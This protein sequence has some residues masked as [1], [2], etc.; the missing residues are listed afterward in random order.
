MPTALVTG[1]STGLG[2]EF[3]E[4]L[5][6]DGIDLIITSSPRSTD[7]LVDVAEMLTAHH[8]VDVQTLSVD[9]SETGAA[10]CLYQKIADSER[11]VDYLVNSA[12]YGIVGRKLQD[13]DPD[14]F[15]RMLMLNVV[16]LSELTMLFVPHMV[17]R[18]YGRILNVSSVAGY[19]VPHGL[20][21]GYA[22]SKAYVRSFSEA[23]AGDLRGTGVTCTHVAPGPTRTEFFNTAGVENPMLET[24]MT[25]APGVAAAGYRAMLA[26]KRAVLP[27]FAS[28]AVRVASIISPSKLLTEKISASFVRSR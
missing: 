19:V 8:G 14:R 17:R 28:K 15:S 10:Q 26:G 21:A 11:A 7:T 13:Y 2:K 20:E 9:L 4:L 1:A 5:A 27:G 6:H 12:G 18:R 24:V 22:A 3:A 23:L 16:A 25:N